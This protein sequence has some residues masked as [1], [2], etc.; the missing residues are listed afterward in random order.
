MESGME[1]C[2][3][4]RSFRRGQT[5]I[6]GRWILM[7]KRGRVPCIPKCHHCDLQCA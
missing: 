7:D 2:R 1:I 4:I 6:N 5:F 3:E